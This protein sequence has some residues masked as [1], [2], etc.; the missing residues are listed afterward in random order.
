M[1]GVD[2]LSRTCALDA[3]I[4]SILVKD[5]PKKSFFGQRRYRCPSIGPVLLHEVTVCI[6]GSS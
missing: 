1:S 3:Q 5:P 2:F 4:E 6:L